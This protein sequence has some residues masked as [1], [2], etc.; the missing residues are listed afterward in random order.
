MVTHKDIRR[1]EF[2]AHPGPGR[3]AAKLARE[4]TPHDRRALH[5]ILLVLGILVATLA[6]S[7]PSGKS[8]FIFGYV[9]AI[10]YVTNGPMWRNRPWQELG[11]KRGFL[12]DLRGSGTSS[13]SS[14]CCSRCCPRA[15]ELRAPVR[16]LPGVGAACQRE[17]SGYRRLPRKGSPR[18]PACL[19]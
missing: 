18:L 5:G 7:I 9:A 17:A 11:L 6:V 13:L 4:P 10:V 14:P 8:I 2:T 1:R 16:V 15:S 12:T 3:Q 19:R